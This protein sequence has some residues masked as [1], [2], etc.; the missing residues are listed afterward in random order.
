VPEFN[1]SGVDP[2]RET[3]PST[4]AHNHVALL[5][6][7]GCVLCITLNHGYKKYREVTVAGYPACMLLGVMFSS[8]EK[9]AS[10]SG[11]LGSRKSPMQPKI[12][13]NITSPLLGPL[14]RPARLALA[15]DSFSP[16]HS[17]IFF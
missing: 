1:C 5:E 3:H 14:D 12:T 7:I 10:C 11:C 9:Q 17:T 6:G 15:Q 16:R 4:T 8:M 2:V 13:H